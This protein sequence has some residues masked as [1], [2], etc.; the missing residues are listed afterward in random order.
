MEWDIFQTNF[1]PHRKFFAT[2]G[3]GGNGTDNRVGG[4]DKFPL[5]LLI[6]LIILGLIVLGIVEQ[7]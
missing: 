3:D 5:W 7:I 2:L 4:G 6:I 1:S